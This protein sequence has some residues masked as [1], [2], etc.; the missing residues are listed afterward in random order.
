MNSISPTVAFQ[1]ISDRTFFL[2]V[3]ALVTYLLV[4]SFLTFYVIVQRRASRMDQRRFKRIREDF[5]R[6]NCQFEMVRDIATITSTRLIAAEEQIQSL[7]A[8]LSND[9]VQLAQP[10]SASSSASV[11]D[12]ANDESEASKPATT[13]IQIFQGNRE[14]TEEYN[15]APEVPAEAIARA[16]PAEDTQGQQASEVGPIL[17]E[18]VDTE[19]EAPAVDQEPE[20]EYQYDLETPDDLTQIWGVGAGNQQRLQEEGVFYFEQIAEWTQSDVD[21]FN[22][23]LAFKGRIEREGW[24]EQSRRLVE[25]KRER[26]AA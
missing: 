23:L 15:Q 3:A 18:P 24:V 8:A 6:V 14:V 11:V 21:H 10:S 12:A 5:E 13:V 19:T 20:E 2:L 25:K 22:E 4:V 9:G 17:F 26:R 7:R 16:N 1:A